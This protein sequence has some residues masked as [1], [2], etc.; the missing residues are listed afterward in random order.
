MAGVNKLINPG[1]GIGS[2]HGLPVTAAVAETSTLTLTGASY[3]TGM[4]IMAANTGLS[5]VAGSAANGYTATFTLF[6]SGQGGFFM[7]DGASYRIVN[8]TTSVNVLLFAP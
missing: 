1:F 8:T 2:Y 7:N 6:G 4:T 5:L 3:P